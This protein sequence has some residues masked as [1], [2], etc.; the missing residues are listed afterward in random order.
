MPDE[1]LGSVR[2]NYKWKVCAEEVVRGR[3]CTYMYT[4]MLEYTPPCPLLQM[5][6]RRGAQPGASCYCPIY[7][8]DLFLT[9]WGPA[10][11]ALSYVFENGVEERVVK[12]AMSGFQKCT[13]VSAHYS[14]SDVFDNIIII[15][16]VHCIWPVGRP[17]TLGVCNNSTWR[18]YAC[19]PLCTRMHQG[20]A[21]SASL[22]AGSSRCISSLAEMAIGCPHTLV[23]IQPV[24]VLW[25]P[26]QS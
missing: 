4:A 21:R 1:H 7:H 5:I 19:A 9:L 22:V 3:V 24:L 23:T 12:S 6:L 11:A 15:V 8:H 25:L 10:I 2:E 16:Q 26:S 18:M 17:H 20:A 14:L 13:V